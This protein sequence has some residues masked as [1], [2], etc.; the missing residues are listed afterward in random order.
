MKKLKIDM[1]LLVQ[2]FSFN[3]DDLGKEYLDTHTGNIINIPYELNNVVHG[4]KNEEN[5]A[6][7]QRELLEDAYAIKKDEERRYI[8]IPHIEE[9]YFYNAMLE[10]S[11]EKVLTENLKNML[12]KALNNTQP[13]R[14]FKNIIFQHQEELDKW[15]DYEEEKMNEY[16]VNWL[17][18]I[19]IELE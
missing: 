2:S 5:L 11:E 19:G 7:W 14:N 1:E 16:A 6:D 10:F 8:I 4:G 18:N 17:K 9:Q 15:Q 13:M 3:D 12:L